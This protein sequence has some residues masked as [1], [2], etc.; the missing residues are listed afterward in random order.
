MGTRKKNNIREA[1]RRLKAKAKR[2]KNK[3]KRAN[4]AKT[5]GQKLHDLMHGRKEA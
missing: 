1:I 4:K 3:I 2:D 5:A